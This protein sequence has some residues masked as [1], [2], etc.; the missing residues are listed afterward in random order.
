MLQK[1]VVNG[2]LSNAVK[3]RM[4]GM[5]PCLCES[6]AEN[7]RFFVVADVDAACQ[8]KAGS[9]LSVELCSS[10][11]G[12]RSV[13]ETVLRAFTESVE[14]IIPMDVVLTAFVRSQADP[15]Q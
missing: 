6:S 5:A 13:G 4:F 9:R 8:R 14:F 12:G 7:C 11:K 3:V 10:S 15:L 1:K 2:R